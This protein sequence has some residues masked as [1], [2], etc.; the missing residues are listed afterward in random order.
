[1]FGVE[2]IKLCSINFNKHNNNKTT[3]LNVEK[4]QV[5]AINFDLSVK[6]F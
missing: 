4:L 1:M 5:F 3:R 2:M 6:S